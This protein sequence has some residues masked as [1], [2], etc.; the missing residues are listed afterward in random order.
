MKEYKDIESINFWKKSKELYGND[1]KRLA[2]ERKVLEKK[3]RDHARSPMQW[4]GGAN[5]G[6]CESGVEPWMRVNDDY[7]DVN[8]EKQQSANNEQELSA[9]QF[10]QRGLANRKAHSDVF[11]YGDFHVVGPES[12]EVF[13]YLRIGKKSG[14]W[15]VVLNF[16]GKK[17]EWNIPSEL[18]MEGWMAGNYV[19]G[20]P[21]E[22]LEGSVG[23]RPWEGILG[24]CVN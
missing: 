17:V 24:K 11:I 15:L 1:P 10:W 21:D 3:A 20:K 22:K 19:K 7:K 6:F 5:G 4:N 14:K 9:W 18:K 12:D 8:A 16:T 23:L 13:A 2:E